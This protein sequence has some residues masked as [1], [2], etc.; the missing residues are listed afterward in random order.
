[1][2]VGN[3]REPAPAIEAMASRG[4]AWLAKCQSREPGYDHGGIVDPL[5]GR[6][7]GDHYATSHFAWSCS[8]RHAETGDPGML[9]AA[10]AAMAFHTRTCLDEYPPGNWDYHWDFNNLAFVESF[11]LVAASVEPAEAQ[12]WR[13]T[14]AAWK[15]NPHWAVNW[16][17]MRAVAHDLRHD[18]LGRADDRARADKWLDFVLGAQ[19]ADGGIEDVRGESLPSQYHTYTAC[20]LHRLLGRRPAVRRAVVAASRWLLAVTAPDGE[21][22][23]LGRGQGQIFGYAC[24]VYLFRAAA[25]LDPDYACQ[26]RWAARAVL[27]R[28]ERFQTAE[29]WWPLVLNGL[30]VNRR[31]GWYDYH[32]L[33]VYNAFA[34]LW[35]SL[36]ARLDMPAGPAEPPAPREVWLHQSGILTVRREHYFALFAAGRPG[37]GYRT[38]AGITP[39]DLTFGDEPFF[40]GPLGPG[41]GKY[42]SLAAGHGQ[43]VNCLAPLW[44]RPGEAWQAPASAAGSLEPCRGSGRWRLTLETGGARWERELVFGRRFIEAHDRLTTPVVQEYG[45]GIEVRGHNIAVSPAGAREV[46]RCFVRDQASRTVFRAWGGGPLT[47]AGAVETARGETVILAGE[48]QPDRSWGWRLRQGPCADGGGALPG[49]VCLSADPWSGLWKRKQRLLF[50]LARL[51]HSPRTLYIEPAVN[52]TAM[53][54]HPAS[55]FGREGTRMR[56]ALWGRAQPQGHGLNLATPLAPWPGGRTF[57]FLSRA[58]VRSWQRQLRRLVDRAGFCDGYV[59]WLYHPSHLDALEVLGDRAE[60]VVYDWTD[61]WAAAVP[62]DWSQARRQALEARQEALLARCDVVFAVSR[63][64]HDRAR[65]ACPEVVLLPNATDPETFRPTPSAAVPHPLATGRPLLVYL[66]QITERLDV[67][68]VA[69]VARIRPDW[70]IILAGPVVCDPSLLDP[71]RGVENVV[72][73]GPLPYEEAASLTARADVCLLPHKTDALTASLDPIKL[74]DYLATGRPIVA[75]RVAM[76]PDLATHVRLAE[77]PREFIQ[78]I[79]ASL[80]EPAEAAGQRRQAAMSHTWTARAAAAAAVLRRYFPV[81]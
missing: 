46:G 53:V 59:L 55:L 73:S 70:T 22:N 26:H 33:T 54:E 39:H 4:L 35:L 64:L 56:H 48:G 72:L 27:G 61:D 77:G 25:T 47:P 60:L 20:L 24:A 1:M 8:L 68:L 75:S 14:L 58:N 78:A 11:R 65:E 34:V 9:R 79:E 43:E 10:R 57:P 71:L 63:A 66:S 30:P 80:G 36:A 45:P 50:E 7:I 41:P 16:V 62:P 13:D 37:A 29:G 42:G 3:G 28:L 51:G 81:V 18:L 40:R 12:G 2:A 44:R 6:V 17:A 69:E 23:A 38:E 19:L 74:Y 31:A 32:H 76:H 21:M 52:V 67:P 5:D 15:T 49:I